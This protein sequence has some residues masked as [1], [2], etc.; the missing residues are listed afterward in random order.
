MTPAARYD[1][2]VRVPDDI[3]SEDARVEFLTAAAHVSARVATRTRF[4]LKCMAPWQVLAAKARIKLNLRR[5]YAADGHAVKE[6]LK[7]ATLLYTC[8]RARV[9]A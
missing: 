5:L 9:P 3:D 2:N 8:A 4:M 7:V 1:P 6:L